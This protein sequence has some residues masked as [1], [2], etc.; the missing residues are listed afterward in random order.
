ML[1]MLLTKEGKSSEAPQEKVISKKQMRI[2]E[3]RFNI[4]KGRAKQYIKKI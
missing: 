2:N 4:N 3:V 1:Q